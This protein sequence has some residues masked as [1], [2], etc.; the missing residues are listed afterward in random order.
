MPSMRAEV[1]DATSDPTRITSRFDEP[2]K[3]GKYMLV[4][5]TRAGLGRDYRLR[6]VRTPSNVLGESVGTYPAKCP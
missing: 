1:L 2:L 6:I 3:P 5:G 4:A